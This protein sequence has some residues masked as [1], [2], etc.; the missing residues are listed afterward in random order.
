MLF[1]GLFDAMPV[2][3]HE[4]VVAAS[5][6][7]VDSELKTYGVCLIDGERSKTYG[8]GVSPSLVMI[9]FLPKYFRENNLRTPEEVD[10]LGRFGDDF[11]VKVIR[12]PKH[13]SFKMG[14][15]G[16]GTYRAEAGFFGKDRIDL[17]VRG[18]DNVGSPIAA[19]IIYFINIVPRDVHEKYISSR[20]Y[21][22]QKKYCGVP[23]WYWPISP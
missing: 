18:M 3:V 17:I 13:G 4:S 5:S 7:Q 15:F 12:E 21:N 19:K 16:S 23:N 9:D 10:W 22:F 11:S 2:P 1:L 6:V 8:T 20:N 14:D